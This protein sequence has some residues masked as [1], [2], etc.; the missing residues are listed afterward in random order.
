MWYALELINN[1]AASGTKIPSHLN[2]RYTM[3]E[4][5]DW[6]YLKNLFRQLVR[7]FIFRLS[8]LRPI[9]SHREKG[10]RRRLQI[11]PERYSMAYFRLSANEA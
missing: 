3:A 4:C 9:V 11:I 5:N 1:P 8:L 7:P 6:K 2:R 10:G